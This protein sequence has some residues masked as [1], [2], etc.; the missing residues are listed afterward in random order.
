M[1]VCGLLQ[2]LRIEMRKYY[3]EWD[4]GDTEALI[5]LISEIQING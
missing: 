1:E 2:D 3:E 5:G 4:M